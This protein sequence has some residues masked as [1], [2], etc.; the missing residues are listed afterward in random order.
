M[1]K[2]KHSQ[3]RKRRLTPWAAVALALTLVLSVGGTV[4][5]LS[6]A[7]GSVTNTFT[8]TPVACTVI[9]D[10]FEKGKSTLKTNVSIQNT[11]E[12]DAH[13]RATIVVTWQDAT[14]NVY[15]Q[16]PVEGEGKDYVLEINDTGW[17][18]GT[19]GYWYCIAADAVDDTKTA[20]LINSCEV[21]TS[22]GDYTLS[23]EIL[24]QA[25]Q[26]EPDAAAIAAWGEENAAG[27][28]V[29]RAGGVQ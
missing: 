2:G 10:R 14:G 8:P 17:E 20:V 18:K 15:G 4:A 7:S 21:L 3:K 1:Y 16:V 24:A 28:A 23:V 25:I 6:T 26:A 11:G 22:Q 27:L 19:D 9:E 5:Y 12:A 29:I 13:I